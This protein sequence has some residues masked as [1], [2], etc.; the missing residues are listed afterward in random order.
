M[1]NKAIRA[2]V[3]QTADKCRIKRN[4]EIHAYG[5][6][7]NSIAVCWYLVGWRATFAA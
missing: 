3:L 7:P 4:G 1:T 2:H 6:A 5:R